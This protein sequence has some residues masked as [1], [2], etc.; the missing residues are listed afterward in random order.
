MKN[1]LAMTISVRLKMAMTDEVT[2]ATP[3]MPPPIWRTV[4]TSPALSAMAPP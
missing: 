4:Q 2:A 3:V 1:C